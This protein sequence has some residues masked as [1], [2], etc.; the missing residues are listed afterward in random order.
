MY[1]K[2][3][4]LFE[5]IIMNDKTELLKNS[6]VLVK[7]KYPLLFQI[8]TVFYE[9]TIT[10]GN[11]YK[12]YIY[13]RYKNNQPYLSLCNVGFSLEYIKEFHNSIISKILIDEKSKIIN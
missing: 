1:N 3:Q 4:D 7:G 9:S 2:I 10:F 12:T 8:K 6:L 5:E 13:V 11:V